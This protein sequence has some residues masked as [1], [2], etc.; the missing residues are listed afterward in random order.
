M[1]YLQACQIA[2]LIR[3]YM[4]VLQIPPEVPKRESTMVQ[5][6]NQQQQQ[7]Q[8][9]AAMNV[10]APTSSGRKS[11]PASMLHR[12]APVIHSQAS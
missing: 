10:T 3:E 8:Q 9:P 6:N 7:Q 2:N 5:Q 11:R 4:E 12:G 1:F